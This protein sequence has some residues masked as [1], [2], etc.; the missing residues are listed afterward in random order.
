MSQAPSVRIDYAPNDWQKKYHESSARHCCLAGGMGSGKTTA[1]VYEHLTLL[2]E[3]PG[4]ILLVGRKT[5]PSLRDTILRAFMAAV[6]KELIESFNKASLTLKLINGS[7]VLFRPLDDPEKLKSLEIS[8]FLI[9]EANEIDQAIYSRLK[10]RTRQKLPDGSSPRYRSTILLNPTDEDHWIPQLFINGNL[11]NHKL[12]TSTTF[13]NMANLPDD[14]VQEL[15][16][17]YSKD[18]LQRFLYGQFGKIHKGRPVFPSFSTN[19][20]VM[21]FEYDPTIPVIRG[22]DFGFNHPCVVW[23]QVKNEQIRVLHEQMGKKIYLDD[24][25]KGRADPFFE[26]VLNIEERMFGPLA[27][28]R[29][30]CDPRGSDASDKGKTSIDILNE[31]GVKPIFRRTWIEEGVNAIKTSLDRINPATNAPNLIIHPRCQLLIEGFRGG[32]HREELSEQPEKD[33]YYEHC[34]DALRY[35]IV[36]LVLRAKADKLTRAWNKNINVYVNRHTGRRIEH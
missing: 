26:G 10:D 25:L 5:L 6:P 18:V 15:E 29:D 1:A 36:H 11:S 12:F 17:T 32:Y 9:E 35:V 20:H 30:F 21:K 24:F 34:F 19:S 2:L 22:W 13:D 23:C 4:A 28:Y 16:Q 31:Y 8:Y 33:G 7:E 27:K 3:H 14:Y